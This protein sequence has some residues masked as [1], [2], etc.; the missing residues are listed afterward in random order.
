MRIWSID[1]HQDE[2]EGEILKFNEESFSPFDGHSY[3]VNY[4]EFSPCGSMLA[5]CSLDGTTII[6]DAEV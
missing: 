5:S 2:E 3:S 1:Q 4:V 6:W